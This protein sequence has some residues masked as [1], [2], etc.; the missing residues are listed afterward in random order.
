MQTSWINLI[1]NHSVNLTNTDFGN[2][3]PNGGFNVK[4]RKITYNGG[5]VN[6]GNFGF[7]NVDSN[8]TT[9]ISGVT[10]NNNGTLTYKGGNGI[11]GASPLLTLISIIINSILTPIALPL[12]TAPREH[13]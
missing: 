5:I 4:G 13:A 2:Q 12:I 10:F 6:G 11:G 9:T 3:T 7:D 8:G 1:S